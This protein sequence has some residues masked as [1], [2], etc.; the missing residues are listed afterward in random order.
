MLAQSCSDVCGAS[1][2]DMEEFMAAAQTDADLVIHA[3]SEE[4][5]KEEMKEEL[6]K[7][8]KTCCKDEKDKDCGCTKDPM[9]KKVKK[10]MEC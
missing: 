1:D 4:E 10:A 2:L 3:S 5:K 6:K 7:E 9:T 8:D